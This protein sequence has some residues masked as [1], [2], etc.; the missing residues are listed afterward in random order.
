MQIT[1]LLNI[2]L[3]VAF[4]LGCAKKNYVTEKPIEAGKCYEKCFTNEAYES[5]R[6]ID[7]LDYSY[8]YTGTNIY[9]EGIDILFYELAPASS[10]WEKKK[11]D[12]NCLSADPNDC[13]VWCLTKIPAQ[14]YEIYMVSDTT[15]IKD[16]KYT[17]PNNSPERSWKKAERETVWKEVLCTDHPEYLELIL[18]IQE[19]LI[20]ESYDIEGQLEDHFGPKTQAAII[21]FQLDNNLP[22][23]QLDL[24]TLDLLKVYY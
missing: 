8:S 13:L 19:A 3:V 14:H 23:G 18:T 16:W 6:D 24:E 7:R 5:E 10:K 17:E 4:S 15:K 2:L 21:A 20:D 11:A 1:T 12:K 22:L 9:Q